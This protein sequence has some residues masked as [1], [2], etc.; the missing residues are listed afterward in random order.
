MSPE[1]S[2]PHDSPI[3]FKAFDVSLHVMTHDAFMLTILL[4][5]TLLSFF[6]VI[7]LISSTTP[8]VMVPKG[9]LPPVSTVVFPVSSHWLVVLHPVLHHFFNFLLS[10]LLSQPWT[11]H[12]SCYCKI[13][14]YPTCRLRGSVWVQY[15]PNAST[16]KGFPPHAMLALDILAPFRHRLCTRYF[17]QNLSQLGLSERSI[18][19]ASCGDT[20]DYNFLGTDACLRVSMMQHGDECI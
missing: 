12:I 8:Y 20:I 10:M 9:V 17:L 16:C 11:I 6:K 3:S 15:V 4:C 18:L 1:K 5:H 14:T 13:S 2:M 19:G 7:G